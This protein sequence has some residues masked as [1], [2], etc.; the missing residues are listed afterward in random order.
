VGGAASGSPAPAR[1]RFVDPVLLD[2]QIGQPECGE[3][4]AGV[5]AVA[6]QGYRLVGLTVFGQ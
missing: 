2:E 3:P 1:A 6:K 5:H 4:V